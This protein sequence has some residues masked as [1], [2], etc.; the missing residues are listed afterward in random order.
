MDVKCFFLTIYTV[1]KHDGVVEGNM[2]NLEE[3]KAR[4]VVTDESTD[5]EA[6]TL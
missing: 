6:S 4:L 3:A 1:L 5:E 2:G